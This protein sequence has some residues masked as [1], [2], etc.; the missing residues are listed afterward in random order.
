MKLFALLILS[1]ALAVALYCGTL[2]GLGSVASW[3]GNPW[4]FGIGLIVALGF[5]CAFL[6]R[7][8]NP[9]RRPTLTMKTSHAIF[10]SLLCSLAAAAFM[11]FFVFVT[12]DR[13]LTVFILGSIHNHPSQTMRR[14]LIEAFVEDQYVKGYRAVDRRLEEETKAGH[15]ACD[16]TSCTMTAKGRHVVEIG[17][18]LGHLFGTDDRFISPPSTP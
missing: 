18:A 13:S 7:L 4:R 14:D 16:E 1:M 5:Q 15:I 10:G 9:L 2:A 6:W 12:I 8:L 11:T 3:L 17:A